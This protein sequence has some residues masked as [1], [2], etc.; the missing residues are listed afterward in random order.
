MAK[1]RVEQL[2][3]MFTHA[4]DESVK[5]IKNVPEGK[6]L[7]QLKA[8]KAHPL[9]LL[10]HLTFSMDTIVNFLCLGAAPQMPPTYMKMFAP[11]NAGGSAITGNAADYPS[12]DEVTANYEKVG[13]RMVELIR[14]LND[15]DLP[16]GPKGNV[17][18]AFADFFKVLGDTLGHMADHD[19]YH[20]GQMNLIVALD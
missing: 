5:S 1:D 12:W 4:I 8:G 6:R 20:R 13:R 14:G 17:P 2:A 11:S 18:P 9:W 7:K 16:G 10:G 19:A 3:K 15:A